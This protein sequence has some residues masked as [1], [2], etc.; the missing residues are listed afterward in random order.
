MSPLLLS[1]FNIFRLPNLIIMII[2][3]PIIR[4]PIQVQISDRYFMEVLLIN[5]F[6]LIFDFLFIVFHE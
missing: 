6:M 4:S 2:I 1:A 3:F 5:Q